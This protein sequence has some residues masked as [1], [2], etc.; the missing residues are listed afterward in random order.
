[1]SR[2]DDSPYVRERRE[3][4]AAASD[5]LALALPDPRKVAVARIA[6][7][8]KQ[9]VAIREWC[10][11]HR[12]A[13]TANELRR[14]LTAL[15][16]YV[17]DRQARSVLAAEERWTERL[18]G[19][20]LGPAENRGPATF[21]HGKGCNV[22][23]KAKH[24]FRA[25]AWWPDGSPISEEDFRA[26]IE[27]DAVRAGLLRL[28]ERLRLSRLPTAAQDGGDEESVYR[29]EGVWAAD[30]AEAVML[31]EPG[32]VAAVITDPPYNAEGV[33]SYG[34][35]AAFAAR[36]LKPGG[37]LVVMVGL[38]HLPRAIAQLS[39]G[40]LAYQWTL[41]YLTLG[42][43]A[44]QIFRRRVN[45]FWRPLLWFVNG[46]YDGPWLGDVITSDV[47]DKTRP[48]GASQRA[49]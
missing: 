45:T 3:P 38:Y 20:L 49:A 21:P 24:E 39:D 33:A 14:R 7:T 27:R 46:D 26:Q 29:S 5:G 13:G 16:K 41:A 8:V 32:S 12:D 2:G 18:I 23:P 47:N 1:V 28:L 35:L 22:P 48:A 17:D 6:E 19:E 44:P 36:A 37:S 31:V 30:I 10:R 15:A 9:A 4:D 11:E 43:G 40:D 34:A 25:L 42:R